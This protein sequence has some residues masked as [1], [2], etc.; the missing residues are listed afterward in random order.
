MQTLDDPFPGE[1]ALHESAS[2][3]S[4]PARR[5]KVGEKNLEAFNDRINI[6][7]DEACFSR[8]QGFR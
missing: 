2:L 8:E 4:H 3:S 5:G 7:N 1:F 6:G